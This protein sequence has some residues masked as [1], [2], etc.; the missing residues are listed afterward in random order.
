MEG[1]RGGRGGSGER[2]E[3]EGRKESVKHVPL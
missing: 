2:G 3:D 1:G